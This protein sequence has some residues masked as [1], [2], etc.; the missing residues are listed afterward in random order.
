MT[1]KKE[2]FLGQLRA[3]LTAGGAALAAFGLHAGHQWEPVVGVL[4]LAAS[5]SWGLYHK[6]GWESVESIIR[7]L[8][9]AIG[10]A[11]VT[12]GLL[13]ED[14][15]LALL[16]V[17]GPA[18]ACVGSWRA[19][20]AVVRVLLLLVLPGFL[21]V[22]C[23]GSAAGRFTIR[24]VFDEWGCLGAEVAALADAS[25]QA[26]A[27]SYCPDGSGAFTWS[28]AWGLDFRARV[29]PGEKVRLWYRPRGVAAV[30]WVEWGEKAGALPPETPG[31]VLA[32]IE[33]E[34]LAE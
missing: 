24:P 7:K 33:G 22:G 15:A 17:V 34:G 1:N 14:R 23:G 12:Y 28:S 18:L 32:A 19:N 9:N 29:K 25:G 4:V 2:V 27:L 8:C 3:L 13:A 10:T 30:S 11:A 20:A 6:V 5:L 26:Y 21:L 16:G 31:P